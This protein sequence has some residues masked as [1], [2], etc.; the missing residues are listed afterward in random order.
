L[1]LSEVRQTQ[2]NEYIFFGAGICEGGVAEQPRRTVPEFVPIFVFVFLYFFC[3][4]FSARLH[5]DKTTGEYYSGF[6]KV[7]LAEKNL[8][9]NSFF[10]LQAFGYCYS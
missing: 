4:L 10:L 9:K 2:K 1:W 5:L 7:E 8:F 6:V 3:S